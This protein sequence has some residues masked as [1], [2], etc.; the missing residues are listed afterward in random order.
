MLSIDL[1]SNI[2][3]SKTF[4]LH[5]KLLIK[6]SSL[7]NFLSPVVAIKFK[8]SFFMYNF[9]VLTFDKLNMVH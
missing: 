5:P 1:N 8:I 7:P 4:F 3:T 2:I 9:F 6:L